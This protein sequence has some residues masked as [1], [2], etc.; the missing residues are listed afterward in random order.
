VIVSCEIPSP[1]DAETIASLH[2]ASWREAY[3]GMIPPGIL[4]TVDM[5]DRTARW[6]SY[7]QVEGSPTYLARVDGEA[8]GFIRAGPVREPVAEGADGHIFALYILKRFHRR[9]IGR[10]LIGLA[11]RDWLRQG[12]KALS[13]GVL[14][15]NQPG[16][17]FYEALG[18]RFVR[19]DV[20]P[21]HGHNLAETIYVF[22][23][24]EELARAA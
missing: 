15:A 2:I 5:A 24:L 14:T 10:R 13:V 17:A 20:Y 23:R 9:G 12:G 22:D 8:A 19:P 6:R 16:V 4:E 3:T 1:E 18:A 7:L 21:W 11:A